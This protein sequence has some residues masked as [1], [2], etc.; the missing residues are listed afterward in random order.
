MPTVAD[1]ARDAEYQRMYN[2]YKYKGNDGSIEDFIRVHA[3]RNPGSVQLENEYNSA[4]YNDPQYP[5]HN[6]SVGQGIP[7]TTIRGF[8][9]G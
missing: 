7:G 1:L 2:E 3:L 6:A 5:T 9:V 8:A 4:L